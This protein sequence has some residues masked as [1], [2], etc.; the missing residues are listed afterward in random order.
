MAK[1]K[2]TRRVMVLH[3]PNLNMLGSREPEVYG[4]LTLEKINDHISREAEGMSMEVEVH[5]SNYEG[6]LVE[7]IHRAGREFDGIILNPGA[8]THYS[9]AIRDAVSSVE[10]P[11]VEIH[12][13]NVH[14]R[15][16]FRS[17]SVIAPVTLG[18]IAG[19]GFHSYLVGLRALQLHLDS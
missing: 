3:G 4:K 13:S 5:Q 8:F 9:L 11:V 16:E 17:K 14:A 18:Q 12:L 1:D 15:E 7:L 10:I 6:E 2:N 19:F